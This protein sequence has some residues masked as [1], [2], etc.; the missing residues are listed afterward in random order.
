[1]LYS[2]R[3]V[4]EHC[5]YTSTGLTTILKPCISYTIRCLY[6]QTVR[7]IAKQNQACRSVYPVCECGYILDR[8]GKI[9]LI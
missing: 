2:I 7:Q 5:V 8:T 1:M 6:E 4:A 9:Q 3:T